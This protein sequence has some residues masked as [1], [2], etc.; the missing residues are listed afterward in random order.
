MSDGHEQFSTVHRSG[1]LQYH[2]RVRSHWGDAVE[3]LQVYREVGHP[4]FADQLVS[5]WGHGAEQEQHAVQEGIVGLQW[6]PVA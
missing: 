4:K 2:A 3:I 1:G 6:A 5:W